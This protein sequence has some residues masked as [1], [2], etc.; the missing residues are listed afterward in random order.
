M[1]SPDET[2]APR[3][4]ST[5]IV[6]NTE[7]TVPF[8][9]ISGQHLRRIRWAVMAVVAAS[10]A[11]RPGCAGGRGGG[12]GIRRVP[13]APPAPFW[14]RMWLTQEILLPRQMHAR[15]SAAVA[16]LQPRVLPKLLSKPHSQPVPASST[17]L[18]RLFL[19][20]L[21]PLARPPLP[22]SSPRRTCITPAIWPKQARFSLFRPPFAEF[23]G[24]SNSAARA[25]R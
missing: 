10:V 8:S 15:T 9:A 25:S 1:P 11:C 22:V 4:N 19:F 13:P 18:P 16:P 12:G 23:T 2:A 24:V 7:D 20:P 5:E 14:P 6:H 3:T 21:L 17:P